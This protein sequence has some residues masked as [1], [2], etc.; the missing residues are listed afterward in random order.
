MATPFSTLLTLAEDAG[1]KVATNMFAISLVEA[2][3]LTKEDKP[4]KAYLSAPTSVQLSFPV[5]V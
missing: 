1:V 3:I 5:K 2:G 4:L